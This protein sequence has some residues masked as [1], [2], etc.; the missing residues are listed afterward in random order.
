MNYKVF[1]DRTMLDLFDS[2]EALYARSE[3]LLIKSQILQSDVYKLFDKSQL[4]KEV[5]MN[6]CLKSRMLRRKRNWSRQSAF[7]ERSD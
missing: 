7:K 3:D 5:S 6:L 4:L 1:Q 2:D